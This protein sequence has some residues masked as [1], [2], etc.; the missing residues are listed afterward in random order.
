MFVRTVLK[1]DIIWYIYSKTS[2][3]SEEIVPDLTVK[4]ASSTNILTRFPSDLLETSVDPDNDTKISLTSDSPKLVSSNENLKLVSTSEE[5]ESFNQNVDVIDSNQNQFDLHG[6]QQ[7]NVRKEDGFKPTTDSAKSLE[8]NSVFESKD[9]VETL[10]A[11]LGNSINTEH[12]VIRKADVVPT[13]NVHVTTSTLTTTNHSV[14]I[15]PSLKK[16]KELKEKHIKNDNNASSSLMSLPNQ[17]VKMEEIGNSSTKTSFERK[18]EQHVSEKPSFDLT[19][20]VNKYHVS[21]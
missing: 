20:E 17:H 6:K 8:I 14:N 19:K 21:T 9:R 2:I 3:S 7:H 4:S 12:Q 16:N 1:L 18:Q 13:E 10:N 11:S 5:L 15:V